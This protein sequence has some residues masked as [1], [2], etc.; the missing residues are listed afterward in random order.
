MSQYVRRCVRCR[1][2][3][4][5][6]SFAKERW[7]ATD[8]CRECRDRERNQRKAANDGERKLSALQASEAE[9]RRRLDIVGVRVARLE[10][11]RAERRHLRRQLESVRRMM[12]RLERSIALQ[13]LAM[14][15][16]T[17]EKNVA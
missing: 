4:S 14:N 1:Q 11:Y 10:R 8:V 7:A 5:L 13:Q 2:V 16:A 12:D 6:S 9:I 17:A 15:D 3:R